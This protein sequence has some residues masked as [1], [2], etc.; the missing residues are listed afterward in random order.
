VHTVLTEATGDRYSSLLRT[1]ISYQ[2]ALL[3]SHVV[4]LWYLRP[5]VPILQC[6]TYG[7]AAIFQRSYEC[8][9]HQ[10]G[11]DVL[12]LILTHQYTL[13]IKVLRLFLLLVNYK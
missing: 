6:H 1:D 7:A 3:P 13:R 2:S 12:I 4:H 5:P 11:L 10:Q 8:G 9:V